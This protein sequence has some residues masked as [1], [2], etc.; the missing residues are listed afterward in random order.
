MGPP[1][2]ARGFGEVDGDFFT[3]RCCFEGPGGLVD[4]DGVREVALWGG[5]K[6]C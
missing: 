1:V 6:E 3:G 2:R 4:L 5:E